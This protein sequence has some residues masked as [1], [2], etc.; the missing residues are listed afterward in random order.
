MPKT[1]FSEAKS[2][3]DQNTEETTA[4][5]SAVPANET[6]DSAVTDTKPATSSNEKSPTRSGKNSKRKRLLT[7][8]REDRPPRPSNA[9]I[10]FKSSLRDG[11]LKNEY[12]ARLKHGD[13]IGVVAQQLWKTLS[14]EEKNKW[15]AA[16]KKAKA[17]HALKYPDYKFKP[18]RRGVKKSNDPNKP[19]ANEDDDASVANSRGTGT[20]HSTHSEDGDD[21]SRGVGRF[22]EVY[23]GGSSDLDALYKHGWKWA[24]IRDFDT[25][26]I[27]AT[28]EGFN[29]DNG[30]LL[31]QPVVAD[32]DRSLSVGLISMASAMD[33]QVETEMPTSGIHVN[34]TGDLERFQE[35]FNPWDYTAP[36]PAEFCD[37]QP[38]QEDAAFAESILVPEAIEASDSEQ[39]P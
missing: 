24:L 5:T 37:T 31:H 3:L 7:W 25:L 36:Q 29:E 20:S 38:S 39:K 35:S 4:S 17:E 28:N 26:P 30:P 6:I 18:R 14:D 10:T 34:A 19:N 12:A 2:R 33:Q 8:E 9:F 11:P 15:Y 21:G 13:N 16:A 32:R 22:V 27:D 1:R 23:V